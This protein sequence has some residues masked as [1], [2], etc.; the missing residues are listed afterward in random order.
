MKKKDKEKIVKAV[1]NY[2]RSTQ[3]ATIPLFTLSCIA[4]KTYGKEISTSLMDYADYLPSGTKTGWFNSFYS[5]INPYS[6]KTP[7][8]EKCPRH[9]TRA[10]YNG[11]WF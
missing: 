7:T 4:D 8:Q 1:D 3:D 11:S 10:E 9:M 6:S 5:A 2:L